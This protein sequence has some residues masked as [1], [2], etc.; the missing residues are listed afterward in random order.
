M[1]STYNHG[2]ID[3]TINIIIV[4]VCILFNILIKKFQIGK[5]LYAKQ[6]SCL[7]LLSVQVY[8]TFDEDPFINEPPHGKTN[9]LPRR[10]QRHR[11]AS[12]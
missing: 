4:Y 6:N 2:S 1:Y 3:F 10:K 11:S 5:M 9:N 12:Q 7:A 8:Q